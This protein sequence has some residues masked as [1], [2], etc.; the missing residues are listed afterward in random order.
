MYIIL[1][2]VVLYYVRG[3]C[4]IAAADVVSWSP[5]GDHYVLAVDKTVMVH[6]I[7]VRTV[8]DNTLYYYT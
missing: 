4:V 5:I 7:E 3:Y 6:S 2:Y 8:E 1:Y